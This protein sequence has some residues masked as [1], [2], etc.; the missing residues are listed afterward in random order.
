[1]TLTGAPGDLEGH[2][3]I[4]GGALE[5]LIRAGTDIALTLGVAMRSQGE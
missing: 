2:G 1:M 4:L 3:R 5:A